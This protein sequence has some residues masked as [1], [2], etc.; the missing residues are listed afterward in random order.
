MKKRTKLLAAI[1]SASMMVIPVS[2]QEYSYR[3]S[4]ASTTDAREFTLEQLD[5]SDGIMTLSGDSDDSTINFNENEYGV[6]YYTNKLRMQNGL[7]PLSATAKLQ[8]AAQI[9]SSELPTLFAHTR[10]DG[11][12][13][14]SILNEVG[15]SCTAAGENIAEGYGD[16]ESVVMQ[17]WNN[18]PGH[19]ANM[20]SSDFTHLGS[21]YVYNP[22]TDYRT[23]WTQVF[24]GTCSPNEIALA[25]DTDVNY[26]MTPYDSID[27]LGLT[28]GA[29][30]KHGLSVLPITQEMC[31]GYNLSYPNT[32]QAVT[33]SYRG[34]STTFNIAVVNPMPFVDVS[35]S[36]WFYPYVATVYY[37]DL[38]TGLNSTT[39]APNDPLAR[40]QFA[41]VLYRDGGT[42]DVAYESIFPDVTDNQWFTNAVI[43][44]NSKK[45][46]T[47][48]TN[49]GM[50]GPYDNITREQLAVMLLRYDDTFVNNYHKT[51][52][53]ADLT[54]FQ[55]GSSV[56]DFAKDAM[57]WAVE[58]KLI[59]GKDNGT[60]LDPQGTA[61]RAECAV[62]LTRYI[63]SI[64]YAD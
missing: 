38:M 36:A 46:I 54:K 28:L 6:L 34:Q 11:S 60:R 22:N 40:A 15:E 49:T 52:K 1:L 30:C 12:D 25:D 27:D 50:F 24:T 33:V 7:Q 9:R 45:I 16:P 58:R 56:S 29:S 21:G 57:A 10:P 48:Y 61:S 26:I 64:N 63:G 39:F 2:A 18:S 37:N 42:P 41:Q 17:G 20:L 43:W 35:K 55:D 59:Q 53:R 44:N 31:S 4:A 14:F 5:Q 19:Q 23:Y 13:C 8:K 32:I 62:I 3:G 51:D 47:G